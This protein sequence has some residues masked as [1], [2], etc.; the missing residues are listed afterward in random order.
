MD[1]IFKSSKMT[2]V[3]QNCLRF[4]FL[5]AV[6]QSGNEIT[7][8]FQ[9]SLRTKCNLELQPFIFSLEREYALK[10]KSNLVRNMEPM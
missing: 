1:Q 7:L 5:N 6:F 3:T 2:S 8:K 4:Q 10:V 9:L